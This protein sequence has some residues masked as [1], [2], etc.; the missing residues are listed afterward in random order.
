MSEKYKIT[1]EING[2]HVHSF[3]YLSNDYLFDDC[4]EAET[5]DET[6]V[7]P[8]L[9]KTIDIASSNAS[10]FIMEIYMGTIFEGLTAELEPK[11]TDLEITFR[12]KSRRRVVDSVVTLTVRVEEELIDTVC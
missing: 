9:F 4:W 12:L 10:D 2:F 11:G 3:D 1:L 8:L 7:K 6:F 5:I